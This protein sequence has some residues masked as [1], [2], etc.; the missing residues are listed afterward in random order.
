MTAKEVQAILGSKH[1]TKHAGVFTLRCPYFWRQ[2]G[3]HPKILQ[4]T[5]VTLTR[6][7]LKY[8]ILDSGDR[9]VAFRGGQTVKEG[10]H[11]WVKFTAEKVAST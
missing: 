11:F 2:V 7:G 10:S 1:I 4:H 3:D 8:K 6:A 9:F 5:D